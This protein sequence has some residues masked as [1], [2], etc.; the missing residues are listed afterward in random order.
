[1]TKRQPLIASGARMRMAREM[2]DY[3]QTEVARRLGMSKQQISAWER[4]RS[5]IIGTKLIEMARILGCDPTWVLVGHDKS[6]QRHK[7]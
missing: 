5:E 3:S 4:G 2:R 6:S 7:Q 1:M